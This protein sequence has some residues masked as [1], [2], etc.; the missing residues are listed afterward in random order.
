MKWRPMSEYPEKTG[1]YCVGHAGRVFSDAYYADGDNT[2]Y[3][4]GW[5]QLPQFGPTH[6]LDGEYDMSSELTIDRFSIE[7][8]DQK[9]TFTDGYRE[10]ILSVKCRARKLLFKGKL[11]SLFKLIIKL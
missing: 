8:R 5:H 4:T 2:H 3:P 10:G 9:K 1:R 7:G 11:I 6:W